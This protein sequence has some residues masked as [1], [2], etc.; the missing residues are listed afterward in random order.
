MM[1]I[2]VL[3]GMLLMFLVMRFVKIKEKIDTEE[4]DGNG[5]LAVVWSTNIM[6]L[7]DL[8]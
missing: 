3:L 6:G 8:V 1:R 5:I 2:V 4:G 7:R